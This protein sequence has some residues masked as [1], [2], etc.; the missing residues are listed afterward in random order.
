MEKDNNN[1]GHHLSMLDP[2]EEI[3]GVCRND[4]IR[5]LYVATRVQTFVQGEDFVSTI[6]R[7]DLRGR[8]RGEGKEEGDKLEGL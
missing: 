7:W 2:Q 5:H 1:F 8:K 3:K 4:T 6:D